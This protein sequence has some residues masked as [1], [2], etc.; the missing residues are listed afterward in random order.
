MKDS[1]QR[2][3]SI[4]TPKE[5]RAPDIKVVDDE[6]KEIVRPDVLQAVVQLAQL[7]QLV[8]IRKSLEREHI[9]GK[10][11]SVTLN[12][13]EEYESL[14]L[15][16]THP[17]APLATGS[18]VNKGPDP[19]SLAINKQRPF[20]RLDKGDSIPVDLTKA[21]ERIYFIEYRCD[22]GQ[23]ASIRALGKY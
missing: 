11:L 4:V 18:F 6:G 7:G 3:P 2:L 12:A 13:T 8:R 21:D 15:I 9:E 20:H 16:K 1:Q 17:F 5:V 22:P 23:T 10:L 19:V 14:D